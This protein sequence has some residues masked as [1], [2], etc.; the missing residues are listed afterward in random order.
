MIEPAAL[1]PRD[2]VLLLAVIDVDAAIRLAR[3]LPQGLLVGLC[4]ARTVSAARRAAGNLDNAMFHP[5]EPDEIPFRDAF[6]HKVIDPSGSWKEPDRVAREATRVLAPSG[7][8]FTPVGGS[9]EPALEAF[10]LKRAQGE[11]GAWTRE[12]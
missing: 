7:R 1:D 3:R 6:F 2:H 9:I 5:G 8:L 11:S 10:G 4:D 12:V